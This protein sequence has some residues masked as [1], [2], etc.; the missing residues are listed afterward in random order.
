VPVLEIV[1]HIRR[2]DGQFVVVVVEKSV[3]RLENLSSCLSVPGSPGGYLGN[4][5]AFRTIRR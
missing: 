5:Q 1:A 4:F 3:Q 2:D